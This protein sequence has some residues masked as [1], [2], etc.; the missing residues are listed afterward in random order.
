MDKQTAS[1]PI[2]FTFFYEIG[3]VDQLATNL[4]ERYLPKGLTLPQFTV[5]NHFVHWEGHHSP[6]ELARSFQVTKGA[7]TNTLKKLE[8]HGFIS[9]EEDPDDGRRKL[10]TITESG[11]RAHQDSVLRLRPLAAMISGHLPVDDIEKL[12]PLLRDM[13]RYLDENRALPH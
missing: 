7:M 11:R 2:V 8:R 4:M 5:L 13:R 10:V 1:D 9:V 6:Y 3:V 12:M